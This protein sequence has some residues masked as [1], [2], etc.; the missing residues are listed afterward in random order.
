MSSLE[1]KFL[2]PAKI[3]RLGREKIAA[4]QKK[5]KVVLGGKLK[6]AYPFFVL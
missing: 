4:G 2:C 3:S 1:K 5:I 6:R